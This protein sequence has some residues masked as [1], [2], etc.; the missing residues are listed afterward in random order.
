[1][2][3]VLPCNILYIF[4][5][6]GAGIIAGLS[7]NRNVVCIEGKEDLRNTASHINRMLTDISQKVAEEEDET[8]KNSE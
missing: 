1:M 4:L 7:A 3:C 8:E 6:T 2:L 5:V